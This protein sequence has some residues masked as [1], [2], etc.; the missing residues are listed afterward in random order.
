MIRWTRKSQ[1]Q[2][3]LSYY[4][5]VMLVRALVAPIDDRRRMGRW[6]SGYGPNQG[7]IN[8]EFN[9]VAISMTVENRFHVMVEY[10]VGKIGRQWVLR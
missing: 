10:D 3:I 8:L 4:A 6:E 5:M 2:R 7:C 1:T 9:C